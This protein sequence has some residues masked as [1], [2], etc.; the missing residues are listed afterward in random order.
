MFLSPNR[1][2]SFEGNKKFPRQENA[3][4]HN[5]ISG[6]QKLYA[7]SHSVAETIWMV[8]PSISTSRVGENAI[9]VRLSQ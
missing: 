1:P 8:L 9:K 6:G 4:G 5:C 7:S 2:P 3:G